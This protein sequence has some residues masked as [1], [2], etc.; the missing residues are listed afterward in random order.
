MDYERRWPEK[1]KNF[2]P[3]CENE[4]QA[5]D[6]A[7]GVD[8]GLKEREYYPLTIISDRYNGTYSGGKYTAWPLDFYHVPEE[9]DEGDPDCQKFWDSY[10]GIVGKGST[11]QEAHDDLLNKLIEIWN[12]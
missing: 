1:I 7:I 6:L 10:K 2:L 11:I 12:Q 9:I 8:F 4:L 3:Y 5:Q